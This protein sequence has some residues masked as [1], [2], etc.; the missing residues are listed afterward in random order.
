MPEPSFKGPKRRGCSKFLRS[1]APHCLLASLSSPVV[2]RVSSSTHSILC[3]RG[4]AC[5]AALTTEPSYLGSKM[6]IDLFL[7][8]AL[9]ILPFGLQRRTFARSGMSLKVM[10][11]S[12]HLPSLMSHTL[13]L[14]SEP[15]VHIKFSTEVCQR[16]QVVFLGCA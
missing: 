11:G 12:S 14:L 4:P 6:A 10:A 8:Q 2:S 5:V 16:T 9:I 3:E 13:M 7:M 15:V 1:Q